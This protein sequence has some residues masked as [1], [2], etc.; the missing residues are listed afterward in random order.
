MAVVWLWWNGRR[1]RNLHHPLQ[2]IQS[3]MA[4]LHSSLQLIQ[5]AQ[6]WC[7]QRHHL[8]VRYPPIMPR[9]SPFCSSFLQPRLW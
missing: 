4:L 7:Q 2:S 1:S 6:H 3:L 9:P 8:R 5:S